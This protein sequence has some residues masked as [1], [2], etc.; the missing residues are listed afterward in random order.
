[1]KRIAWRTLR[2]S[3]HLPTLTDP[4]SLATEQYRMLRV[5]LD[6]I[7]GKNGDAAK[8]VAFSSSLPSEGKTCTAL[9][10]AIAAAQEVERRVV[11]V[12]CDLR[13]QRVRELLTKP[14]QDGLAQV[15]QGKRRLE[16]TILQLDS[17]PGLSFVLAGRVP[18]N[19]VELLASDSM[20]QVLTSLRER[21]DRVI[22]D[23]PPALNFAD[24]SR[25]GPLVDAFVLVVRMGRSPRDAILKTHEIL[26][27]FGVAGVVLNGLELGPGSG[28][29]YYYRHYYGPDRPESD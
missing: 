24:A 10:T 25:L 20:A 28:Y 17:L 11:F 3:D 6:S 15:L 7:E 18:S 12:E 5:Q 16:E 22:V 23:T 9:N 1:V 2:P 13:R 19:P 8:V 14:P 26:K 21:F 27:P 4:F 29:G